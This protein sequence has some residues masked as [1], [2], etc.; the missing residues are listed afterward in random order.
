MSS[1]PRPPRA[2]GLGGLV[3]AALV[4][5]TA[6][7]VDHGQAPVSPRTAAAGSGT[8]LL[9]GDQATF[10]SSVGSW[11]GEGA[12]LAWEASPSGASAGALQMTG[13]ATAPSA[14]APDSAWS[15]AP[16]PYPGAPT[17]TW[18]SA[19]SAQLT[20]AQAGL[21]YTGSAEV[22]AAEPG[23]TVRVDAA[24][25]FWDS[26]G[27]PL[28]YVPGTVVNAPAGGMTDAGA[29]SAIAPPGAASVA[30]GVELRGSSAQWSA[31]VDDA[32]LTS[33]VD[34]AAAV[35]GPLTTSGTQILDGNGV[36]VQL[37]G[38]TMI[39]LDNSSDPADLTP[40]TF[41]RL[42]QW[43]FT[44]VRFMLNEDLWDTQS[45]AYDPNYR[46][47]V[48]QAV[49]WTTA[50]GMVAAL[51]L[52]AGIPEDIGTGP[53]SCP[54][55]GGQNTAD[56]PGSDDFWSTVAATFA[57]NP[58]V[59]FDLFNE[60]HDI[61][62]SLWH[63]GGADN[64]ITA[65][66]MQGLYDDVRTAGARNLVLV[67]GLDWAQTPPPEGTLLQG[68]N[69][70]YDVHAYTC[71]E[72]VPPNC[73][74][75]GDPSDPT[76]ELT[77]WATFQQRQGVPV[78]V[79]EFGWPSQYDDTY[80]NNVIDFAEQHDWGWVAY[81][82]DGETA[83]TFGVVG[84]VAGAGPFEPMPAGVGVLA[85]LA[86]HAGPTGSSGTGPNT[87]TTT[88]TAALP[89]NSRNPRPK[90]QGYWLAAADGG[91]FAFGAPFYG[92]MGGKPLDRP[93]VAM[94]PTVDGR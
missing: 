13:T 92:S 52:T 88:T 43:G 24:L 20:A 82:F 12:D 67:E 61:S 25:A 94:A 30:L 93:I 26:A 28:A 65:Q 55:Q 17:P 14:T 46:S 11:V 91:I 47:A 68:T 69:I 19:P 80:D 62:S 45:C 79:G 38:I 18:G 40:S 36:P 23:A 53:S 48:G 15:G 56:V 4:A 1:R 8:N 22:A 9:V 6:L 83:F 72:A 2:I 29:V 85:D 54:T 51:T 39:N 90:A 74:Y 81:G 76:P 44:L 10:T 63:S 31:V 57:G 58:L 42:H 77:S 71:P 87:P 33:A 3:V 59:V 5:A 89:S 21:V 7:T 64:G 50:Q 60:P 86:A 49:Q 78:V 73:S 35:T 75:S 16:P 41:S 70:V 66:G 84:G 27:K 34:D 37:R 32:V